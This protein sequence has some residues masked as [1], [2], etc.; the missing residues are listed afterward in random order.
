MCSL[1]MEC[2]LLL[3]N[4]FSCYRHSS[5]AGGMQASSY[6]SP[7][8]PQTQQKPQ[9]HLFSAR[10]AA[11]SHS[12]TPQ[13]SPPRTPPTTPQSQQTP[14]KIQTSQHQQQLQ[15]QRTWVEHLPL[16]CLLENPVPPPPPLHHCH[17]PAGGSWDLY[18]GG[19]EESAAATPAG[20][21]GCQCIW[22][23]YAND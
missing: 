6:P 16:F 14:A 20:L 23:V 3:W 21:P 11:P 4:V 13:P 17:W 1:A 10:P 18:Q 5:S 7:C 15:S 12:P 22:Y 8:F 2:V 9:P 19:P